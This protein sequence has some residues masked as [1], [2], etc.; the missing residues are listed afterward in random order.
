[1]GRVL[2][3]VK[4]GKLIFFSKGDFCLRGEGCGIVCYKGCLPGHAI[5]TEG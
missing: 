1:M 3:F 2:I 5:G 4:G